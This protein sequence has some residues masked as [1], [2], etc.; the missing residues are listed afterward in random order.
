MRRDNLPHLVVAVVVRDPAGRVY[1]H[2]RTDTK[3][4][5][6]GMHDAMV[7]GTVVAGEEPEAAAR[8]ELEEELGITGVELVPLF[9]EWYA[10]ERTRHL[11]HVWTVTWAGPVRHQPEE[12]AWGG[13]FTLEEL[14]QA[15][16]DPDWPFVPDG[17]A[18]LETF[19][20][21]ALDPG[22]PAG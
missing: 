9:T 19:G 11:S 1:V 2:R 10:D 6:P 4:V 15:L 12:I 14:E 7:A 20:V 16:A 21:R 18:L 13:W 5:F 8:R 22:G 3:D 17:R